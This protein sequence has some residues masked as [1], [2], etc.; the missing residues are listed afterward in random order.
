VC[1]AGEKCTDVPHD[2]ETNE[3]NRREE[4]GQRARVREI[5]VLQR[6]RARKRK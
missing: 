1:D 5:D 2:G 4:K 3:L 6:E